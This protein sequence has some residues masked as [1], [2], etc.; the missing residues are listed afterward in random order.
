MRPRSKSVSRGATAAFLGCLTLCGCLI[1]G[2]CAKEAETDAKVSGVDRAALAPSS[3]QE[4]L[5]NIDKL[6]LSAEKKEQ[7]KT[8]AKQHDAGVKAQAAETAG[9]T[10]ATTG[11]GDGRKPPP[12][13]FVTPEQAGK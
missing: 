3:L 8:E 1:A 4:R 11:G 10:P 13:Y 5:N 6:N 7:L 2:G 12:G 9:M